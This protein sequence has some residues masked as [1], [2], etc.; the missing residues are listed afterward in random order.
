MGCST[1][2]YDLKKYDNETIKKDNFG[3]EDIC[4]CCRVEDIDIYSTAT[5]ILFNNL[6][7]EYE[8]E[9]IRK[10]KDGYSWSNLNDFS[11]TRKNLAVLYKKLLNLTIKELLRKAEEDSDKLQEYLTIITMLDELFRE[12]KAKVFYIAFW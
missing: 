12:S 4:E 10:Y 2:F 11:I 1:Y 3:I 7:A 5:S 8:I 6:F 9:I